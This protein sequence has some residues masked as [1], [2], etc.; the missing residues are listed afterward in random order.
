MANFELRRN[1]VLN[2]MQD[3]TVAF[4]YSGVSKISNED[5]NY[6]FKVNTSF[7]YLTGIKQENSLLMLIKSLGQTKVYLFIDEY[8]ELKEKWTGKRINV[9][10]ASSISGINNVLENSSLENII[11]LALSKDKLQYGEINKIYLDL[12]P[13]IKV[14]SSLSTIQKAEELKEKYNVEVIDIKPILTQLRMVKDDDEIKCLREA[15]SITGSAINNLLLNLKPGC[16]E[17]ELSDIFEFYGR[18]HNRS[19][20]AFSTIC[21]AGKNATCLHYPT[22]NCRVAA[23]DLVL[24][25]L[26][27][28]Y[29]GYCADIS[30]TYPVNGVYEGI[31]KTI[32]EVVLACNK[33]VIKYIRPGLTLKDLQEYTKDFLYKECVKTGLMNPNEEITQY[34]YHNIS[35]HLGLDTHDCSNRE[36]PLEKG[37]VITVE[38]GLYFAKYGIGVR[39]EDDVVLTDE[40]CDVLSY[41]IPKEISD[42]EKLL[43][44][45]K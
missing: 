13:E 39:I 6:P 9:D 16:Y 25:D 38:P 30:R 42:I 33:A 7:F 18:S 37:N 21:A 24:F 2:K 41:E 20:L 40:G 10:E 27:L 43:R 14:A 35:H 1:N 45:R 32:Y 31:G 4:I 8:S 28:K 29:N 15:I 22:Q 34:Y 26:G 36:L 44:S 23:N 3:N 5:E 19:E 12:T 17:Y 11:E